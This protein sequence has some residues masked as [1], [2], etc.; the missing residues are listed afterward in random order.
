MRKV[1]KEQP[2]LHGAYR[3]SQRR[4]FV[5]FLLGRTRLPCNCK[6]VVRSGIAGSREGSPQCD[7]MLGLPVEYPGIEHGMEETLELPHVIRHV[8][9]LF[10]LWLIA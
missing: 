8:P 3:H 10:F 1:V 5:Q 4:H 2:D 7:Q 9:L 6:A